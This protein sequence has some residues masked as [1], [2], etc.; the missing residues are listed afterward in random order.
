MIKEQLLGQW[1]ENKKHGKGT[2]IWG[3]AS[4]WAGDIY[5]GD[6]VDGNRT[7]QGIYNYANGNV[8]EGQF[9][10]NKMHGKGK[11]KY[12]NGTVKEGM[13]SNDNFIG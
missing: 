4:K 5:K 7:G 13:W 2:Y 10:E 6:Y 1:K 12:A 11:M 9:K 8:Y 3:P